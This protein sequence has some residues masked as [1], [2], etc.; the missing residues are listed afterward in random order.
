MQR[1]IAYRRNVRNKH[2]SRKRRLSE[3]FVKCIEYKY[4]GQYSKGKIHCS[5]RMCTYS[6]YHKLKTFKDYKEEEK[7][8]SH[9]S[10]WHSL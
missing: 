8:K 5:C 2:I 10:D 3:S 6:K 7:M 4:E 9:L 1:G